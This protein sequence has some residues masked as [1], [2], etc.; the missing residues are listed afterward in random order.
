MASFST[1]SAGDQV[2]ST[3]INQFTEAL[4][5]QANIPISITGVSDASNWAL[6]VRNADATNGR[7]FRARDSSGG[8]RFQVGNTSTSYVQADPDGGGLSVVATV[9]HPQT[10]SS[11]TIGST[12]GT[13]LGQI[14]VSTASGGVVQFRMGN[15][16]SNSAVDI[17]SWSTWTPTFTQVATIT[18]T[19]T[20]ARYEVSGKKATVTFNLAL[21]STG[22]AGQILVMAGLPVAPESSATYNHLGTGL[23][24]ANSTFVGLIASAISPTQ[25]QFFMI[26][27]GL[28]NYWGI[29]PSQ[30]ILAND[31]ISGTLIYEIA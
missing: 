4:S 29:T 27:T 7:T 1:V 30:G 18:T 2:N 23:L 12:G 9:G 16:T 20:R 3:N 6:D 25:V 28:G 8:T 13:A 19:I 26:S 10:L 31:R 11:K 14:G 22:A 21:T 24:L 5:G 15:G 17:G